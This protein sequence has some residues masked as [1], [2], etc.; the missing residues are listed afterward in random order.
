MDGSSFCSMAHRDHDDDLLC[1]LVCAAGRGDAALVA[2]LSEGLPAHVLD[3]PFDGRTALCAAAEAGHLDA[4]KALLGAGAT[5][6]ARCGS[7]TAAEMAEAAGHA[8]VAE[9]L[10]QAAAL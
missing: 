10:R 7:S 8:A 6:G 1:A 4:V 3:A 9:A 2:D 5:P